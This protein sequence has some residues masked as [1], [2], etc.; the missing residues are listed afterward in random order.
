MSEKVTKIPDNELARVVEARNKL[1][2]ATAAAEKAVQDAR[3]VELEYRVLVQGIYLANSLPAAARID[4]ETG[5]VTWPEDLPKADVTEKSES[6]RESEDG[7][8]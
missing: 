3:V 5:N 4:P 2:N 1:A 7:T 8:E 6:D